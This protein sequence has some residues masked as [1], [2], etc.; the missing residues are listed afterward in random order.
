MSVTVSATRREI[1]GAALS[2]LEVTLEPASLPA[3]EQFDQ[4]LDRICDLLCDCARECSARPAPRR[5]ERFGRR[6]RNALVPVRESVLAGRVPGST[7][8]LRL[9][10]ERLE[11]VRRRLLAAPAPL[12]EADMATLTLVCR[13]LD[14]LIRA[15]RLHLTAHL[16]VHR[17]L[18]VGRADDAA[19][20]ALRAERRLLRG[21]GAIWEALDQPR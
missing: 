11:G 3:G 2:L 19:E 13:C 15:L 6:P 8:S 5:G 10:L 17:T 16:G 14:D 21:F 18:K 9:A 4:L 1:T 12:T 7:E 20:A